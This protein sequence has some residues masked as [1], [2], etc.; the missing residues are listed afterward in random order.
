MEYFSSVFTVEPDSDNLPEFKQ[1]DFTEELSDINITTELVT[2]K[3]KKLKIDKS[4]GPDYIHPRVINEIATSIAYPITDIYQTSLRNMKLPDEWKVANVSAIFKKGSKSTPKNYRPVSLT[5][6]ICKTMEG[7]IRDHIMEH[8]LS[9]KLFSDKQFGFITGR[10]TTLQLLHVLNIWT[11]ILDQGGTIDAIYC[12]FMK[13]FD[14]V[15]HKRLVYKAKQYG[16]TGKVH[17]WIKDFLSNRTHR[18]ALNGALSKPANVTSGIPQGSVLGPMLFVIYIN[19]LPETVDKDS[20]IYLFADDA[21]VFRHI[22]SE[23]DRIQ[24]QKDINSL[25][26]WS[27]KWLLLFHP[28]KCVHMCLGNNNNNTYDMGD[29]KL[30]HSDCEKDLGVHIDH[31]LS[32]EKHINETINKANKILAITRKTFECIDSDTFGFV[33]K[34]LIRPHLE[35]AAPVWSPHT[36]RQIESLENVQRRA[37]KLIPG[38][39]KLSYPERLKKLK[40]PTLA[41]RRARG[42]MI[43]V[44]KMT[45]EEGY[46]KT[47]PNIFKTNVT[48][49]RGHSK[50]LYIEGCNKN[51]R[52][53]SFPHRVT[54]IWNSLPEEVINHNKIIH[55][56]K[57]LDRYWEHQEI[58]YENFKADIYTGTTKS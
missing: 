7:I 18:V 32:F 27:K 21:K 8:M 52:K 30:A 55:F 12:D 29:H 58:K 54:K 56:E 13:A 47:L 48:H 49:L 10:S 50:K 33:F 24:L 5:S 35:Y 1:R 31:K 16:I 45:S 46:D 36:V 44:F 28:D 25:L 11:E 34:G 40:L 20:Y 38:F 53:Y 26:D 23:E 43:Q 2:K 3:L 14:K 51:I 4:P 42:D 6:I 41:Y 15:S 9:N 22:K 57:A 17:G 19:D 39:S 37:T